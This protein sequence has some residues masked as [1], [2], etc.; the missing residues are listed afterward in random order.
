MMACTHAHM[1]FNAMG[2]KK[3]VG[4]IEKLGARAPAPQAQVA[5]FYFLPFLGIFLPIKKTKENK[6]NNMM[7]KRTKQTRAPE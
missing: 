2:V 4:V 7:K 1:S 6:R 3:N 5:I